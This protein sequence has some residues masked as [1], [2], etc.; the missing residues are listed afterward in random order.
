MT[1]QQENAYDPD[2]DDSLIYCPI[3]G[4]FGGDGYG[5]DDGECEECGG[6]GYVDANWGEEDEDDEDYSDEEE[7]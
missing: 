4:G 1:T 2:E 6:T 5:S 7:E 3:C